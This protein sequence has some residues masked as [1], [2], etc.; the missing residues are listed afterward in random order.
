MGDAGRPIVEVRDLLP[1][2][3]QSAVGVLCRGM[4]DNPMNVAVLGGDPEQRQ[5]LL[6]RMFASFFRVFRAQTPLVAIDDATIVG[7]AGVAP[8]GTC[9]PRP[10]QRL[11]ALPLAKSLGP[12]R[13][14]RMAEQLRGWGRRDLSQPHWHLGP[15]AV[16][17]H[18]QGRGVGTQILLEHCRRLDDANAIGYLETDK[19]INVRLYERHGYEVV[20]EAEVIGVDSWFMR[21]PARHIS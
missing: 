5:R 6:A 21:R 8:P 13:A 1:D 19:D 12:R 15:L 7:V 14:A 4:R 2:E 18:L 9:Q 11:R 3:I 20:D 17:V 16:D 10:S